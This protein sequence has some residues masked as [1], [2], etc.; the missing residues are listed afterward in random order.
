[1]P[2]RG[3]GSALDRVDWRPLNPRFVFGPGLTRGG[4]GGA[5]GLGGFAEGPAAEAHE[6]ALGSSVR[7][8]SRG[9]N[10]GVGGA[11]AGVVAG[12]AVP[13]LRVL[14]L[15]AT[16]DCAGLTLVCANHLFL[17]DPVLSAATL[18]QLVGRICR[19]GQLK[20]CV[21]YHFCG[22]GYGSTDEAII[23]LRAQRE[24]AGAAAAAGYEVQERE[25]ETVEGGAGGG[26]AR[27]GGGE[28]RGGGGGARLDED[29]TINE[30][31]EVL[32]SDLKGDR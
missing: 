19:V 7:S 1:M 29:L 9:R 21:V 4:G 22:E 5:G 24:R 30:L 8:G 27:N 20:P 13:P 2:P 28:A 16:A 26:A 17:L 12:G 31:L 23:R 18:A 25:E 15:H 3:R 6:L 32:L 10:N 14:L 11:G